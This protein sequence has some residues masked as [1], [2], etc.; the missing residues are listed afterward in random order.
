M[1]NLD[2]E[3]VLTADTFYDYLFIIDNEATCEEEKLAHSKNFPQEI[4]KFPVLLYDTRQRKVVGVFH[5]YCRPVKRPELTEDS[6]T[7]R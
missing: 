3:T 7:G 6:N 1:T 5:F 2:H 4:I